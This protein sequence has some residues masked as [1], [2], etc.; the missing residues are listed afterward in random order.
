MFRF[1]AR[2]DRA[3]KLLSYIAEIIV[4]GHPE[5]R[6]KLPERTSFPGAQGFVSA[7][8]ADAVRSGLPKGTRDTFK[9]LG[10]AGFAKWT[11]E[12]TKLL[13]TDTTMRDAHQ[14][15]FA[16]RMR[17]FDM[18]AIADRYAREHADL[19]SLEM[20]G[21][22]TF[23]TAM[24]FLKE[25]PWERL[26]KLRARVP[27]IL[28]QMLVRAAS[29][30]G[31]TNY[32]DNVVYE[33]VRLSA[34]AGMDV[35]RIFDA[36]NW[37][38]NIA[39]G[40]K[41]VLK[42]NAICEAAICYTGDILDPKRDK[43]TLTY[44][45]N[46][47]KELEK[48]GTHFLAIKD[49]AGLLKPYAAKRLVKALREAVGVPIHFHTHD[50]A[51]GQIASYL[52]AAEEGVSVVDC[53]FA[54]MAGV[55]SQPSLNALVEAA[56]FTPRDTGLSFDALQATANYWDGVR[57]Q[58]APFET[59]QLA[60]SAEVY[61]HEMPGGQYANLFQQAH[62]LG[63]G[64]RWPE[65]GRMYAAVNQMF[66]DIVKVTPTSKVVGDMTLFMLANNLTPAQVLDANREIAFPESVVE[67][68]E[69]KLGQPPGGF[70]AALQ[71]R[72]LRGRKPLTGRPG[73][74]LPPADFA[75][76]RKDLEAKLRHPATEQDVVSYLLYP[77]VFPEYA[78]TRGRYSDLSVLPTPAFFY[79]MGTGDEVGIEI[80]PGKTL[81]IKFLTIGEAQPDG[82]RV[83]YF[84]LNGQPREVIVAD[85][86]LAAGAV[87]A[88]AKAEAG[89]AKHVAAPM[90]G[91]V[92]AVAVAA[93]DEIAAGTKLLTLEA[94]KMETTLHAERAGKVAEVLVRPGVPVEGGDLVIRFE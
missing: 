17:T 5:V 79:G 84:E 35:F 86:S 71:A 73:A 8:G 44:F 19:F 45:V 49:M 59:G 64:D 90:P 55:T 41:A 47:A 34:E 10:A 88:R 50:S 80:E 38:P 27:N 43:Y 57:K 46:L 18:L 93:G 65:V 76:A 83:V 9:E 72:V 25:S 4:N 36:N 15:L 68:F 21:G 53:A 42:T 87:K 89:N 39:L 69:G 48:L 66:G 56:R 3:S 30:V 16:T 82:R 37:L 6:G 29:A 20:W 81:I 62:S 33:F 2:R 91:A 77:K 67:F 92:V 24:R 58:Y 13:V 54:P 7:Q 85:K 51:G 40:I 31:Y 26:A 60:S 12:Q 75:A 22:A 94:M 11:R 78:E 28:F 61:L 63:V 32:P 74:T 52:M 23:D 70:P 14:S 1:T